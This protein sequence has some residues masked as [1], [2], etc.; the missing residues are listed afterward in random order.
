MIGSAPV[1]DFRTPTAKHAVPSQGHIVCKLGWLHL[2]FLSYIM[3]SDGHGQRTKV[4]TLGLGT[5]EM[6]LSQI[7]LEE[8][9][10]HTINSKNP[11][12]DC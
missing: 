2:L 9:D 7:Y 12:R 11:S 10:N 6:S 5:K 3:S 8:S 1:P 4:L